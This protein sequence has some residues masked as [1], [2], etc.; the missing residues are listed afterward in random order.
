MKN[1]NVIL[2]EVQEFD[3]RHLSAPEPFSGLNRFYRI[4][5]KAVYSPLHTFWSV[6]LRFGP[7]GFIRYY[8]VLANNLNLQNME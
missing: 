6:L 5:Q 4:E 8:S 7:S 3:L 2:I 1:S